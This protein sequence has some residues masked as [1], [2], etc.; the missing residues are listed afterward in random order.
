MPEGRSRRTRGATAD[1]DRLIVERAVAL[2]G[3]VGW[4]RVRLRQVAED[5]NI[6]LAELHGHYRDLDAVADAWFTAALDRMLAPAERGFADL[7]ARERVYLV[8]MRWFEAQHDERRVVGEMLRTKLY[9]SHPHH[10]V[11]MIFSLSR[12]IQWVREAAR[13]DAPGLRRQ[14]EEV[15]LTL[16]FLAT[17][18]VWLGDTSADLEP[19]RRF[20]RRRLDLADRLLAAARCPGAARPSPEGPA[21]AAGAA[22]RGPRSRGKAVKKPRSPRR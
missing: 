13:L 11:P 16:L 18:P 1:L 5:L 20:L 6:S 7:P 3:E 22:R 4:D 10:W 9:P 17:L 21:Q 14:T 2:A 12:L 8:M 19:T 15:G